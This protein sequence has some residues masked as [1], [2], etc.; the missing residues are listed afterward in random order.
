MYFIKPS[1]QHMQRFSLDQEKFSL[2]PRPK[3]MHWAC[4]YVHGG[5]IDKRISFMLKSIDKPKIEPTVEDMNQYNQKRLIHTGYKINTINLKFHD[6]VSNLVLLFWKSYLQWYFADFRSDKKVESWN[7]NT[8]SGPYSGLFNTTEWGFCPKSNYTFSLANIFGFGGVT[9][10]SDETK[11]N[12]F[13]TKIELY[14]LYGAEYT[15]IIYVNPKITHCD[16][17]VADTSSGEASEI[18]MSIKCEGIIFDKE[19]EP[20]SG[21]DEESMLM[22]NDY[23][24]V[25]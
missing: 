14:L 20:V 13:L 11:T 7:Y 8:T 2:V 9:G 5:L 3:C 21:L 15:R 25:R 19:N 17:D 24:N 22:L 23:F 16:C 18:T 10:Q 1:A 4:F 6:D 12:Y